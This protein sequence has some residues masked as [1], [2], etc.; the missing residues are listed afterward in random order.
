MNDDEDIGPRH[1]FFQKIVHPPET[2]DEWDPSTG[3]VQFDQLPDRMSGL[4]LPMLIDGF[5]EQGD[6]LLG[7][8][9]FLLAL[10]QG[11]YPPLPVLRWVANAFRAWHDSQGKLALD[12]AFG[13]G[14]GPGETPV[15]KA[16][17]LRQRNDMLLMDMSQLVYLGASRSEAAE[18]VSAKLHHS[19]WNKTNW[20]MPDLTADTLIH[21]HAKWPSAELMS[22]VISEIFRD[23]ELVARYLSRF[24][25]DTMPKRLKSRVR[26]RGV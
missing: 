23:E 12:H 22:E 15:F 9:A 19:D 1:W 18:M 24:D 7:I 17:L 6:K 3:L 8:E 13:I 21:M 4:Q 5:V 20:D 16:A 10:D 26:N 14:P 25:V 2:I 11:V